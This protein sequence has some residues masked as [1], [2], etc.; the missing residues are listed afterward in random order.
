MLLDASVVWHVGKTRLSLTA[1]NLLNRRSYQYV[2]YGTL[3]RTEHSFR[4][5]GRNILAGVQIR[6]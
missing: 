2:N 6:F 3:S 4:L 5:R 1:N